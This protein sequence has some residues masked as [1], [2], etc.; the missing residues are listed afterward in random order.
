MHEIPLD[1]VAG[2]G[3][4]HQR[5]A[6]PHHSDLGLRIYLRSKLEGWQSEMKKIQQGKRSPLFIS[7][8]GQGQ[9]S[10][11]AISIIARFILPSLVSDP[12]L[13]NAPALADL[14]VAD[15]SRNLP[16]LDQAGAIEKE[17]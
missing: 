17:K 12:A 4:R 14:P 11:P 5:P 9:L 15:P 8:L 13:A 3:H 7:S 1:Q 16:G 10:D 6:G 2:Y